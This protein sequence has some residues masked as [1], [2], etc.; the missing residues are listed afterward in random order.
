MRDRRILSLDERA[1]TEEARLQAPKVW[2]R[3]RTYV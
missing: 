1:I 2:E 3:Y